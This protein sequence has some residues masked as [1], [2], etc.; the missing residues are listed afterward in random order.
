[1]HLDRQDELNCFLITALVE[2]NHV[3]SNQEN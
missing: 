3:L 2:Q 1:L